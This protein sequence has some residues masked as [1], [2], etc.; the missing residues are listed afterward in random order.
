M[1][2]GSAP[3]RKR[4]KCCWTSQQPGGPP[5]PVAKPMVPSE[6]S[7][8]TRKE[9]RTLMPQLVRDLRYCSHCDAGVEMG[10]S[11]S[12]HRN[13]VRLPLGRVREGHRFCW[14][15]LARG[16]LTSDL[17]PRCDSRHLRCRRCQFLRFCQFTQDRRSHLIQLLR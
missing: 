15:L 16:C 14:C 10:E 8:S 6:A 7:I 3:T 5:K 12:L 17:L 11:M 13:V 1:L 4:V 2:R 9:P